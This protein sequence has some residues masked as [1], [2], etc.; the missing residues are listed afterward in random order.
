MSLAPAQQF[1]SQGILHH[2]AGR[3]AEAAAC[4]AKARA[5]APASWEAHHYGGMAALLLSR[6]SEATELFSRALKLNP[7]AATSAV[8][9]GLI[10]MAT[11]DI[12]GAEKNLRLSVTLDPGNVQCWSNLGIVLRTQ[13]RYAEAVE[14]HQRS[15]KAAPRDALAWMNFGCTLMQTDD[16]RGA[17]D[18]FDRALSI[19]R[20]QVDARTGRAACLFK[21]HRVEEAVLEYRRL[22]ELNPRQPIVWSFLLMA[23]NNLPSVSAQALFEEHLRYGRLFGSSPRSF[24]PVRP[25][26]RLKVAI[27]SSDLRGHSVAFF[28]RPLLRHA[29]RERLELCVY[30]DHGRE[31][32]ISEQLR[33]MVD[34][35]VNVAGWL[36]EAL[37]SRVIKD[38]P[39]IL[40]D[41]I[42]H[43]G[44][45]RMAMV[46]QRL[47][48]LQFSY[49]GYPNTTGVPAMDCRLVDAVTDPVGS[50]EALATEKLLR[51]SSCAWCYEPPADSPECIRKSDT[52]GP[53]FG[54][55]N[56]LTKLS[57]E[58]I[59]QWA[60]LLE[61][62]PGATLL[63]K[64]PWLDQ[65]WVLDPLR[66]RLQSLGLALS[67]VRFAGF[68]DSTRSHLEFYQQ[69][70]VALDTTP[71]NGTTTTCEALWMGVPVVSLSGDRHAA[72]VGQSILGSIGQA[73]WVGGT[74]E[75]YRGIARRLATRPEGEPR[76]Q[77]L[78]SQMRGSVLMDGPRQ[79]A[80]FW[81]AIQSIARPA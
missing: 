68:A 46:S 29:P 77:A 59:V 53:V 71:Y 39:D 10:Q 54:C 33:G 14:A 16:I 72:R 43:T 41:L 48:A 67:R 55:F 62:T 25:T 21:T 5:L 37:S 50:A 58:A 74:W 61:E 47:A 24:G 76:G 63:L 64:S 11:G 80:A 75:E 31:D 45:S 18:K 36:D 9:L 42:G 34:S 56:N 17:M 1:I 81:E 51:F 40:L 2:Q 30:H 26:G 23:L 79:A 70:D 3:A 65:D 7:R 66:R 60:R 35:W 13:A 57:D 15:V 69:I 78:R 44:T 4:Y 6:H 49:L 19:D 20:K 52:Q 28:M 32:A 22:L 8:A 73:S 38:A 12:V 27:L